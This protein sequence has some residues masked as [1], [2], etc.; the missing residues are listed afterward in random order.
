MV[1]CLVCGEELETDEEMDAHDHEIPVALRNA[2]S[3]FPCPICG[4]SFD[5]EEHLV[6][7]MALEHA[8]AEAPGE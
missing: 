7:H 2:G 3:G 8:G 6:E 1:R 4:G 5:A